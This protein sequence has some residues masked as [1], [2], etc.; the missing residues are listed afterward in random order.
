MARLSRREL[1]SRPGALCS[2]QL[3]SLPDRLPELRAVSWWAGLGSFLE[4]TAQQGPAPACPL[5]ETGNMPVLERHC[6]PATHRSQGK[7]ASHWPGLGRS[8]HL[9]LGRSARLA[10]PSS[11]P[12]SRSFACPGP[13]P[14]GRRVY[15]QTRAG[16]HVQSRWRSLLERTEGS[17]ER[18][19]LGTP[20]PPSS[21][22]CG[23][24]HHCWTG[25][26]PA[27]HA[28]GQAS[29]RINGGWR[30]GWT[31]PWVRHVCA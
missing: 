13:T 16:R 7:P 19:G 17:N 29:G 18:R 24:K 12:S 6:P 31:G 2:G 5:A 14:V 8:W 21:E 25:G 26:E 9:W 28:A 4:Q 11:C 22:G 10:R 23:C 1:S 30:W 27:P 3:L 15:L 20:A